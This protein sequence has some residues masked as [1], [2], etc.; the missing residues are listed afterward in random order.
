MKQFSLI[1][2]IRKELGKKANKGKSVGFVPTM[3]ALHKGHL[4]LVRR[5]VAENDITVCS[6][7]V[8]PTQFNNKKDLELY[9]RNLQN[10]MKML[11]DSGCDMVF[12]PEVSEMY[13]QG[14][15]KVLDIDFG[16]LER[17]MEGKFRPGH[18]KGVAT[19][20]KKLFDI[21]EPHRA[22]FGMKDY[23]Q[24]LIIRQLVEK[25]KIPVQ[26][27][28]CPIVREADG[29]AM[30]SRN[31][32]L[33]IGERTIAPHVFEV[34][35]QARQKAGTMSVKELKKW[36]IKKIGENPELKVEYVEIVYS[37]TLIPVEKW[38]KKSNILALTA[39]YLGGVRL[40]D[41][42]ELFS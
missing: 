2:G 23:Q 39:V 31:L 22:Y 41:N 3:G 13:P 15:E 26:I 16:F 27:I 4:E 6:I 7:F 18:F 11:E 29:L 30:S 32:R 38:D 10:D 34:L 40:I 25:L 20:V 28:P 5:S 33:T 19:V 9:P 17:T 42:L 35:D 12:T 36:T 24:L 14:E 37:D 21:V 1:A 8:N